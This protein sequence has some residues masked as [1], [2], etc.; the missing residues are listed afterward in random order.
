[1]RYSCLSYFILFFTVL[2]V[3]GAFAQTV[4]VFHRDG[5]DRIVIDG[6]SGTVNENESGQYQFNFNNQNLE[7]SLQAIDSMAIN[8]VVIRDNNAIIQFSE[9]VTQKRYFKV[10][11][12]LLIDAYFP[13][14]VTIKAQDAQQGVPNDGPS[15]MA[16]PTPENKPVK[17]QENAEQSESS[18][19]EPK[20]IADITDNSDEV[21]ESVID[22]AS[23]ESPQDTKVVEET[24]I[25]TTIKESVAVEDKNTETPVEIENINETLNVAEE[26]TPVLSVTDTA[27]PYAQPTVITVSSTERFSLAVFKRFDRLFIVTDDDTLNLP[28]QI[29]GAGK[30]LN[31]SMK[32]I[33]VGIGRAWMMQIPKGGH[34]NVEGGGVVW[35]IILSDK[36][37]DLETASVSPKFDNI[38]DTSVMIAIGEPTDILKLVDPDYGDALAILTVDRSKNRAFEYYNFIDFDI[39]PALA[40]A[41]IKP[42]SDGVKI[43]AKGR[44]IKITKSDGLMVSSIRQDEIARSFLAEMNNE[45]NDQEDIS[46]NR[47]FFFEDWTQTANEGLYVDRR[48]NLFN[49]LAS[50]ETD[51]EK[52]PILFN[53]VKMH[54]ADD[55]G[56]EALGYLEIITDINEN[57]EFIPQYWA[58]KGAAHFLAGQFDMAIEALSNDL[59]VNNTE[60]ILWRAAALA[61]NEE[62]EEA[63]D[64]YR[65]DADIAVTYPI[66]VKLS[67]LAPLM[68]ALIAD[69]MG[70]EALEMVEYF[71]N[72]SRP[73]TRPE[74]AALTYLK[75]KS[76]IMSGFPEEAGKNLKLAVNAEPLG[77]YGARAELA[78]INTEKDAQTLSIEDAVNRM[79]RLRFIWR[80]D[81][82]EIE[83][84][85]NLGLLYIEK[86]DS[87]RGLGLLQKAAELTNDPIE[88]RAFVRYMAEVY[89]DIFMGE[90][91]ETLDPMQAVSVYDEFRELMPVGPIGDQIIDRLV[92]KLIEIDLMSRAVAVLQD[93]MERLERGEEAIRTG[94]RIAAIQLIDRRPE[95]AMETLTKVDG[96]LRVFDGESKEGFNQKVIM[97]KARSFADM[98]QYEAALFMT[99]GLPDTIDVLSLRIDTAWAG[100]EWVA[101][102]DNLNKIIEREGLS[103]KSE[104]TD[105]EAKMIL[106]QAV[107]LQLSGQDSE[108]QKFA[109]YYDEVMD[110]TA[111][112][113]TF[114]VVTRPINIGGLADRETLLDMTS[115]VDLFPGF[116]D[117]ENGL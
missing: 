80:G 98:G 28:P 49:Q 93:K 81:D 26:P 64:L 22:K 77:P 25:E 84:Y 6:V 45:N 82:L 13:K 59:V 24:V 15:I 20:E 106:N 42:K 97:L 91:F 14:N 92:D 7:K 78:L 61:A 33:P 39:I 23:I 74:Y 58:L 43:E 19:N 83:I 95:A 2:F 51:D 71:A 50:V 69:G 76:Q 85:D 117:E 109:N 46:N 107:A 53:L 75:G 89:Q 1:M 72:P 35:R 110:K 116:L 48:Q 47:F 86:G 96:M 21:K 5:Y 101:A 62:Y 34:I 68:E 105:R 38:N 27:P 3:G 41:V 9:S 52:L 29:S 103:Q 8:T 70:N 102:A 16:I 12:R 31:W 114:K 67:V 65:K 10:A 94:L 111:L 63:F 18:T 66:G 108:L 11:N 44:S 115:E 104:L 17:V 37:S 56:P 55:L 79:E 100:G 4:E 99:E 36:K 112:R 60:I 54:L 57:I 30:Q 90:L 32:S 88:R 73:L 87:R 40:G 113:K